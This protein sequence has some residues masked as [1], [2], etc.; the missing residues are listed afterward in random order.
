MNLRP[1]I[2]KDVMRTGIWGLTG[3]IPEPENLLTLE[4]GLHEL[5]GGSRG[6]SLQHITPISHVSYS[7]NSLKGLKG[8]IDDS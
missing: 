2:E 8:V 6:L 5:L 7:L 4:V 1:A 3:S